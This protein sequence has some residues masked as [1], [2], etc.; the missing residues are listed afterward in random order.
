MICRP[1]VGDQLGTAR[2]VCNAW[3]VGME[4]EVE[5]QLEWGKLQLAID[6]LMADNDEGKEV[7]ERM[8][9]LTNMADKGV[10]EG[11]SSHTSF[12]NLVEFILSFTC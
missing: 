2:Y 6:K 9:Y 8:K 1:L 7:R 3:R 11:G 12:V 10:S 5:T 4:V